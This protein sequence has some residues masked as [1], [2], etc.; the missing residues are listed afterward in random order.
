MKKAWHSKVYVN[1]GKS[2]LTEEVIN[3][4]RR[5]LKKKHIIKVRILKNCPLL[6]EL[7]RRDIAVHIAKVIDAEL[8]GVRG[9]VFVLRSKEFKRE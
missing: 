8:I 1:I 3:E 5:R 6:A 2:G 9:Y 7:S 4:L